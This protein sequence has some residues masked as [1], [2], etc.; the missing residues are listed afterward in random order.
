[1]THV[2]NPKCCCRLE[3]GVQ[4]G[5]RPFLQAHRGVQAWPE[6]VYEQTRQEV[7]AAAC[8][9]ASSAQGSGS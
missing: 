1:M 9:Y 5:Q 8:S 3:G 4:G 6:R 7:R 2:G